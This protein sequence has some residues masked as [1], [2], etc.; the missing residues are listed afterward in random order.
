[1]SKKTSAFVGLL[2]AA[3]MIAFAIF[4]ASVGFSWFTNSVGASATGMSVSAKGSLEIRA[5]SDGTNIAVMQP[6][7]DMKHFGGANLTRIR[8]GESGSFTFYVYNPD[9][10]DFSFSYVLT[11]TNNEFFPGDTKNKG[12]YADTTEAMQKEAL[13]H[14]NAH[15]LFFR[16][17]NTDGTYSGW[18]PGGQS[19]QVK[20]TAQEQAVT[21]Y[22]VWVPWYSDIFASGALIAEKD[23]ADI[24]AYYGSKEHLSEMFESGEKSGDGYNKADY[25][26]GTTLRHMCFDLTVQEE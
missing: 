17:K 4:A 5:V 6:S 21:V 7:A 18:I 23:R 1:M 22:W 26:I 16:E 12:F 25:I 3:A 10:A 8:P 9:R 11:V 2:L 14:I 15:L 20:A 13:Q 24:A 19:E